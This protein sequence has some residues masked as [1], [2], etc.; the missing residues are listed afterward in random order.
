MTAMHRASASSDEVHRQYALSFSP[1]GE[2]CLVAGEDGAI[3]VF[4]TG[5]GVLEWERGAGGA[6]A[7][8]AAAAATATACW[9]ALEQPKQVVRV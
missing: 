8:T 7:Q 9:V 6:R 4:N 2:R 3:R 1:A 5:S